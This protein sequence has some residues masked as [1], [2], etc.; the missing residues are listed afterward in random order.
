MLRLARHL[1]S[2]PGFDFALRERVSRLANFR[3]AYY[4]RVRR[5]D[6]IDGGTGLGL[7]SEVPAGARLSQVLEIAERHELDLDVNA[8]L[9]LIRQLVPAVALLHQNARDVSHGAIA[10]ERIVVTP[11]ARV[12][13]VEYV[14]GAA[15]E[16]LGYSR[17]RLWKELRVA[18]PPGAGT[19]R[20]SHRVDVMQIGVVALALVLGRPLRDDDLRDPGMLVASATENSAL[21]GRQPLSEP[22]RRWLTRALQLDPR[23]SFESALE[24]QLALDDVL[25]GSGG[26]VAA[27]VALESFLAEYDACAEVASASAQPAAA[28]APTLSEPAV[29]AAPEPAGA[30]AVAPASTARV[31]VPPSPRLGVTQVSADGPAV[32][33]FRAAVSAPVRAP[34]PPPVIETLAGGPAGESSEPT[35][36]PSH[37]PAA[38]VKSIAPEPPA[39]ERDEPFDESALRARFLQ[40]SSAAEKPVSTGVAPFWRIA[41]MLLALVAIGEGAYIG[42][43]HLGGRG[44]A[45]GNGTLKVDSRPS[46]A[47]VKIDGKVRGTTPLSLPLQPGAHVIEIAAGAEPRVIPV[48]VSAGETLSQYVE[49]AGA[50]AL[51]RLSIASTPT[52]ANVLVNGQ[53]RGV[54]PLELSDIEPGEHEIVLELDGR[55][56]RQAVTVTGGATTTVALSLEGQPVT[57][58]AAGML[59]S[60]P[61]AP[62]LG[63][64]VVQV[65]F[66]MRVLSR[67]AQI[68]LTSSRL[69]LPPGTYD[70]E[71]VSDT[72]A[73][74]TT[75]RVD[76]VAGKTVRLPV[77]LPKGVV[78][79][80]ATPWAEVW[81]DGAKVGET[82]IGNLPV[83]IG[84]HEIVFRHPELGEQAH[85]ATVTAAAPLRLSVDL[86]RKP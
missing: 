86:T 18:V 36:V 32:P 4:A 73:F 39:A 9:C 53:P 12:V 23:G 64:L 16:A 74:R 45:G 84:P 2:A 83:T 52:G 1:G 42:W 61:A 50:N 82:P 56:V 35:P 5:V 46:G 71:I 65:P 60:P 63:H 70:L 66:E 10:P 3:H 41:A 37:T 77:S 7:V 68:G 19:P 30:A 48:T 47:E 20:L 6:R 43:L 25:S 34:E 26:Y 62:A 58:L 21:G 33:T 40:A 22:L 51:G 85:A 69:A 54:T 17:E 55:R 59:P 11:N 13:I 78:H 28:P 57:E 67:G 31:V 75:A 72:L 44:S 38:P 14:L 29:S 80:N 24:A 15:I 8:A 27:P 76:I 79:L 81:I 49:L